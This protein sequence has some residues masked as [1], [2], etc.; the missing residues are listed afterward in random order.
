MYSLDQVND[1]LKE[2]LNNGAGKEEIIREISAMTVGWP[3]VFGAWGEKCTPSNRKRR[4]RED[5]PTIVS[6]CQVLKGTKNTCDKCKWNLPV[7]MFD[8]RG[9]VNYIFDK[10]G[11]TITGAGCTTQWNT[12]KNWAE[13]GPISQM[14]K[15]KICCVFTGTDAKK[16]HVGIYLGDGSTIECSSGV[17]Y[18][19]PMKTKWK[20]YAIP[21][22]LYNSVDI[23]VKKPEEPQIDKTNYPTLRQGS[24]GDIV[25]TMQEMLAKAGSSLTVDGI[26]GSG[27]RS[28]VTA[29]QKKY[30]LE[31][32]GICGPKTW[33]KLLE[34]TSGVVSKG[35]LL[36]I[37]LYNVPEEVAEELIEKYSGEVLSIK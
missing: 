15:D 13:K 10:A 1:K 32:D 20:Y 21:N 9:Y 11:V 25:A 22:G 28:A 7:G 17:Q 33:G 19:K 27:T 2:L 23:P 4:K 8:C 3:Y 5:H 16:E 36:S 6:A 34:V 26:F 29:F 35:K 18:F 37:A 14:P 12:S 30:G 31:T 24:K